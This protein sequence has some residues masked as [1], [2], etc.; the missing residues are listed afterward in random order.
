MTAPTVIAATLAC[1]FAA[2]A[3]A[4]AWAQAIYP[5]DRAEILAGTRFDF[6]VEFPNA[7]GEAD[8]SVTI[9]GRAP[10]D[11]FG[12]ASSFVVNEDN[13]GRSALWLRDAELPKAGT[14]AVEARFAGGII[15][16]NWDVFASKPRVAKNVILFIGDGMSVAHRTAAR[17]LSKGLESGRYG[18]QLAMDDMSAIALV[19]TSGIESIVTDS[20]NSMSAYVTGHKS[21]GGAMGVY[22]AGN[23]S[24]FAHPRVETLAELVKR[25]AVTLVMPV[26][27]ALPDDLVFMAFLGVVLSV[28]VIFLGVALIKTPRPRRRR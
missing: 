1:I 28:L 16:A 26:N 24:P 25:R 2:V 12:K 9:N 13:W 22:C 4:G 5:V 10:A 19:S 20:A 17:M 15:T 23:K 14:Y 11:V 21:C 7:P 8:V 3:S 27:P 6:K 18:G